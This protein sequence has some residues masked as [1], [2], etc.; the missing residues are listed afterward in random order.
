[1]VLMISFSQNPLSPSGNFEFRKFC[2]STVKTFVIIYLNNRILFISVYW[3]S[4]KRSY[5]LVRLAIAT[6]YTV[7]PREAG[8][9]CS[10]PASL[11][12]PESRQDYTVLCIAQCAMCIL[13][14]GNEIV[15]PE[16]PDIAVPL[17]RVFS[18]D[19]SQY[20]LRFGFSVL[21]TDRVPF[22]LLDSAALLWRES[23][24]GGGQIVFLNMTTII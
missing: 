18:T 21:Y 12:V 3:S 10:N 11:R 8:V 23:C 17:E 22:E 9:P 6:L 16:N 24:G 4:I 5:G 1:M 20:R 13:F 14:N 15:K 7:N 19:I 2:N